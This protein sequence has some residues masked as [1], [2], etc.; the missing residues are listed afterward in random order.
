ETNHFKL[1]ALRDYCFTQ[2]RDINLILRENIST[3]A[4]FDRLYALTY[5]TGSITETMFNNFILNIN[6]LDEIFQSRKCEHSIV[7]YRK[8]NSEKIL[9]LAVGNTFIDKGFVSTS[10]NKD[11]LKNVLHSDVLKYDAV[12]K[13]VIPV[14]TPC[15]YIGDVFNRNET[16]LLLDRGLEYK[17]I[18]IEDTIFTFEIV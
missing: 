16:E 11:N 2:F 6:Q 3:K 10:I 15:V 14:D 1:L 18:S 9:N 13:I 5:G 8:F 17:L 4:E 12:A 7:T